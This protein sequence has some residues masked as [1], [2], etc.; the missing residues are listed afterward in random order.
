M[1]NSVLYK[2][3][4][5][6]SNIE[7]DYMEDIHHVYPSGIM[8]DYLRKIQGIRVCCNYTFFIAQNKLPWTDWQKLYN[9]ALMFGGR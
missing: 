7:M 4:L 3:P 1:D 5:E 6:W 8:R 2:H 9:R